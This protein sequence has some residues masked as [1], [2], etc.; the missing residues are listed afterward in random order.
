MPLPT[1]DLLLGSARD[2]TAG[3]P[4]GAGG[5]DVGMR[6]H[7]PGPLDPIPVR[8]HAIRMTRRPMI[9]VVAVVVA[10]AIA[11]VFALGSPAT[12]RST[13]SP[14]PS[15]ANAPGAPSGPANASATADATAS[16]RPTVRPVPGHEVFGF[17][18][19]WEMT[20]AGV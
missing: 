13:A 16:P 1:P 15:T 19:Y 6:T 10:V 9:D 14:D 5:T 12:P 20:D 2:P 11:L 17:V 18:P 7:R 8:T 3:R 4:T